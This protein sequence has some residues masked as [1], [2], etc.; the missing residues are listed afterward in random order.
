LV[1]QTMT[2]EH[3]CPLTSR[4][5][6]QVREAC[7]LACTIAIYTTYKH[8]AIYPAYKVV[9][10]KLL[11]AKHENKWR[12]R[13]NGATESTNYGNVPSNCDQTE[14][15]SESSRANGC[16]AESPASGV[17]IFTGSCSGAGVACCSGIAKPMLGIACDQ[18]S[19]ASGR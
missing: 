13:T 12:D 5:K 6:L 19:C 7:C 17:G 11:L 14:T 16:G 3:A 2:Q 9:Q 1:M 18:L 10:I 4:Q 15:Y 8:D